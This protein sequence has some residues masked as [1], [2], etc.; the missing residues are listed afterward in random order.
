[1]D[2]LEGLFTTLFRDIVETRN[3]IEL[4]HSE[5]LLTKKHTAVMGKMINILDKLASTVGED[6][7]PLCDE[8]VVDRKEDPFGLMQGDDDEVDD[9]DAEEENDGDIK[10]SGM[11]QRFSDEEEDPEEGWH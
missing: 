6:L 2:K 1:M 5:P 7:V 3:F 9:D 8:L 11:K 10:I 4:Q